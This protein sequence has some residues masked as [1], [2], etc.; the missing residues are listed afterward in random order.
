VNILRA[1]R[2]KPLIAD[3]REMIIVT[4][5]AALRLDF[6]PYKVIM[7]VMSPPALFIKRT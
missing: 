3:I 4:V 5:F 1:I 2:R 7:E 6:F